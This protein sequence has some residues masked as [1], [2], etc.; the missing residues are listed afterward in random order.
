MLSY[1]P[2]IQSLL[3]IRKLSIFYN[4]YYPN[5]NEFYISSDFLVNYLGALGSLV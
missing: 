1:F 5:N 4:S 3:F 2:I